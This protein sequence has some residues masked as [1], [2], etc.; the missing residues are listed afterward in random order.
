M[1]SYDEEF[2]QIKSEHGVEVSKAPYGIHP[3]IKI[4]L[5]SHISHNIVDIFSEL[6]E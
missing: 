5:N 4:C 1:V 6:T 2:L 3:D